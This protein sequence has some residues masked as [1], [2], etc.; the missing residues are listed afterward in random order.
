MTLA[1]IAQEIN[2]TVRGWIGYYGRFYPSELSRSL[3]HIDAYLIRWVTKKYKRMRR[4][5]TRVAELLASVARRE[6]GLFAHWQ[7]GLSPSGG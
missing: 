1:E 2:P 5:S 4:R 3:S 6:P 7:A